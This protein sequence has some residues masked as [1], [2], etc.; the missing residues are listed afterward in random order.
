M[1]WYAL[2]SQRARSFDR[3]CAE[4]FDVLVVGG[5]ATGAGIALEA[6]SRGLATALL[7]RHDFSSGTSSRSTKLVHGGVRYLEQAVR[8][9]DRSQFHLVREAL[10]ERAVLLRN[11]PHLA[12]PLPL[13]TPI[14]GALE[15]PYYFTGLKLYD[16]LAGRANLKP[17]RLINRD[18]ATE[19]FPMLRHEGLRGAVEYHDGQFDDA[20]MNVTLA[21]TAAREGA[22]VLNY[23]SVTELVKSDGTVTGAVVA[24]GLDGDPGPTEVRARVV[25][26]ATGPFVDGMRR[27]DDPHAPSILETSSGIHIVLPRRFSPP[28][29]GLLIPKTEDGRVLFLLPWLG[30]TLV[31]TTDNPAPVEENPQASEDDV[32]YLLRHL[33]QYFDLPVER[34]DVLATWSGLRPLVQQDALLRIEDEDATHHAARRAQAGGGTARISR[35]HTILVSRSGLVTVTGGKWTTYRRMAEDA[36]AVAVGHAGLAPARDSVTEHLKLVGAEG[37]EEGCGAEL[38]REFGL[39]EDVATHLAGAYGDRAG[40]VARLAASGLAERLAEGHPY[41]E[42]EVVYARDNEFAHTPEDVLARRTRLE[43]LD[44]KAAAAARPRVEELLRQAPR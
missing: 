25:I 17:S 38:A 36:V 21:L 42:A 15:L 31:G 37:Y 34:S 19:R 1:G 24:G 27:L 10:K 4:E 33:R 44:T 20:R 41:L 43:F 18:Q 14:Y 30:R 8:H 6:A 16:M 3:L 32:A 22:V 28:G 35:D 12:H 23:G 11:A 39:D 29:T 5:G 2:R 26:N 7:E 13:L 40:E 9:A